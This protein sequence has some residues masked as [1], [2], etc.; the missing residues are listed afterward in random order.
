MISTG[1]KFAELENNTFIDAVRQYGGNIAQ[2]VVE[3]VVT[4]N[5]IYN[6]LRCCGN[7]G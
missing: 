2:R 6:K 7:E 4:R 3:F 5:T 1:A